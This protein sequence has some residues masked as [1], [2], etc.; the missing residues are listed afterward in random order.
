MYVLCCVR[1]VYALMRSLAMKRLSLDGL[2]FRLVE[3][4]S[5]E[6]LGNE[7]IETPHPSAQP[8]GAV[9]NEI[10]DNEG[11]ETWKKRYIYT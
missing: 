4:T 8:K 2:T 11:I 5:D 1:C 7:G 3:H 6:I 9:S 10:P